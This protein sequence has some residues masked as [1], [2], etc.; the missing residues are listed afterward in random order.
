V[1][2]C[3]KVDDSYV[4]T[5]VYKSFVRIASKKEPAIFHTRARQMATGNN[6]GDDPFAG[7]DI[8]LASP[9]NEIAPRIFKYLEQYY[10]SIHPDMHYRITLVLIAQNKLS[11]KAICDLAD[12]IV[13]GKHVPRDPEEYC[14]S[15]V[16]DQIE[17][18]FSDIDGDALLRIL[19]NV[20]LSY[21]R[22]D[23]RFKECVDALVTISKPIDMNEEC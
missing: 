7:L 5:N 6:S 8:S 1:W 4:L 9:R 21:A 3:V 15:L 20:M 2:S 17:T 22:G 23:K 12:V 11:R 19:L 14:H 13:A 16:N 18:E 10:P